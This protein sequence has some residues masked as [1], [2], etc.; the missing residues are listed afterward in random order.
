MSLTEVIKVIQLIMTR[1]TH[2]VPRLLAP[3]LASFELLRNSKQFAQNSYSCS[4]CLTDYKG[5]KCLQLSCNHIFCRGCLEDFWKLC[6]AEGE[7]GRVG[8]PDPACVKAGSEAVEEE[9]ARVVTETELQ[10]WRW[11]REKRN[12]EKGRSS[13]AV[14]SVHGLSSD[15]DPTIVHCPMTFCQKPVPKPS[16]IVDS[17]S[18]WDRLRSCPSCL[19][20]F[21][22]FCKR[23]W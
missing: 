5:S 9:V 10:R 11:L 6:I 3:V 12:I 21:C 23:T 20:S 2:P 18:G 16:E 7:V 14:V 1:I 19:F 13:N 8:C 4:V 15:V 22:S 17:D